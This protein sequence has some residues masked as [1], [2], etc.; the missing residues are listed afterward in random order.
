MTC[1]IVREPTDQ[2]CVL[3]CQHIL[4]FNNLKKL[5][6][7]CPECRENIEDYEI[8]YLPQITIYKIYIHNFLNLVTFHLQLNWKIQQIIIMI[9]ISCYLRKRKF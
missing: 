2:L 5:K 8:R 7:K 6:K 1:P 4:S 9:L 3:K